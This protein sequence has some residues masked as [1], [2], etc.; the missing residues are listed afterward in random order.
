L[1]ALRLLFA[2]P[3][4]KLARESREKFEPLLDV[5]ILSISLSCSCQEYGELDSLFM[6]GDEDS[7]TITF[8]ANLDLAL[9]FASPLVL[10]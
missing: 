8:L 7:L 9:T 6:T 5:Y 3:Y 1:T 2:T 10:L 4:E